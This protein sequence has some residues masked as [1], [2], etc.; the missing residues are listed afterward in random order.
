[1]KGLVVFSVQ[2]WEV[3]GGSKAAAWLYYPGLLLLLVT[4]SAGRACLLWPSSLAVVQYFSLMDRGVWS[5]IFAVFV[6]LHSALAT[7]EG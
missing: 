1:M 7:I 4:L 2:E 6:S 3:L 5:I